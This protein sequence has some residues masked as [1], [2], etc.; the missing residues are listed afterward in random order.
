MTKEYKAL[1]ELL[2]LTS[3]REAAEKAILDIKNDELDVVKDINTEQ[4]KAPSIAEQAAAQKKS[5]EEFLESQRKKLQS[6]RTEQL[7]IKMLQKLT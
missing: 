3:K 1:A 2:V 6:Y 7:Q 5:F 4:K